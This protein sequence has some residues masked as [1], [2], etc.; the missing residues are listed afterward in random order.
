MKAATRSL[1]LTVTVVVALGLCPTRA[2][3]QN[4]GNVSL[5]AG[6][7]IANDYYFRGIFQNSSSASGGLDYE[8]N[9]FY[10][11][12]WTAD[13]GDGLEV[14]GYFGYGGEIDGQAG[15]K[16][17]AAV[18]SYQT[19]KG[20]PVDGVLGPE[21]EAALAEDAAAEEAEAEEA[22]TAEETEA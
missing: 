2:A 4:E 10:A 21:T 13:V 17:E 9:G 15:P 7:D 6:I 22:D 8:Q 20:L 12:T 1:A 18:R 11:G 14:D 3:A 5:G 16:T 19:A